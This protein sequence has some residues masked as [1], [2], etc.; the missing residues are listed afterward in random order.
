MN[1][2]P[3]AVFRCKMVDHSC[4]RLHYEE[5]HYEEVHSGELP[6]KLLNPHLKILHMLKSFKFAAMA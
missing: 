5:V 1:L 6:T 3:C 4:Q 2:L